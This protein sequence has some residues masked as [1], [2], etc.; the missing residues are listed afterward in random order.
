MALCGGA[1]ICVAAAM[2]PARFARWVVP[3]LI[4]VPPFINLPGLSVVRAGTALAVAAWLAALAV[5]RVDVPGMP[6]RVVRPAI[7]FTCYTLLLGILHG[8]TPLSR[9][10]VYSAEAVAVVWLTW[11]SVRTKAQLLALVDW[12]IT[13]VAVCAGLALIEAARQH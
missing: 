4:L 6:Q 12:L 13:L 10:L 7:A 3:P 1:V 11:M 8:W 2:S 9:A 5:T